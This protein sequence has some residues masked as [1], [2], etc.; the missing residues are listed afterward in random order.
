MT[1]DTILNYLKLMEEHLEGDGFYVNL[2]LSNGDHVIGAAYRPVDRSIRID[3]PNKNGEREPMIIDIGYIV[4]V[5]RKT[6]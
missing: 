2:G 1:S 6:D 3:V 4:S 5:T